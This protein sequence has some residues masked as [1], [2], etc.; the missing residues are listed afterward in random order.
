MF[1]LKQKQTKKVFDTLMKQMQQDPNSPVTLEKDPWASQRAS[2]MSLNANLHKPPE[3]KKK[4]KQQNAIKPA[5][6]FPPSSI[7]ESRF[8]RLDLVPLPQ[9][10]NNDIQSAPAASTI[11]VRASAPT[12]RVNIA[13]EKIV[14]KNDKEL[15]ADIQPNRRVLQKPVTMHPLA[16]RQLNRHYTLALERRLPPP[17]FFR[18]V[19]KVA[20]SKVFNDILFLCLAWFIISAV[21]SNR[22]G[23]PGFDMTHV[24]FELSSAYGTAGVSM[25]FPG[26]V[27]DHNYDYDSV[28]DSALCFV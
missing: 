11:R 12:H 16:K 2:T 15:Q 27:S 20:L 8:N 21:E 17:T 13:E 3:K 24:L 19:K 18:K 28:A 22:F 10:A 23:E 4:G 5:S 6:M 14:V 25:G 9:N 26:T 7:N 1:I